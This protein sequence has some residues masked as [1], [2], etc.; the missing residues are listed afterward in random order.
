MRLTDEQLRSEL[1]ELRETPSEEFAAELDAWAAAGFPPPDSER[2]STARRL[3]P[4]FASRVRDLRLRPFLPAMGMATLLI[5]VVIAV[6]TSE[7]VDN[8]DGGDGASID[9]PD[10]IAPES[11]DDSGGAGDAAP[12]AARLDRTTAELAPLTVPPA[13]PQER[14]KPSR[15][16]VQE[17]SASIALSTE[18]DEVD[19]V[20]DG[21]V[22]VTERYEGIVV[23]S[24]V[25]T[26]AERGRAT[27][28]LRIPTASL[29]A[30]LADLSDLASVSARNEG[31]LDI[32]APFVSAEE[33]F[34]DAK[35]E[36]DA[37]LEELA[38][39][40]DASEIAAIRE[41]LRVA[42]GELSRAR[43]ELGA[44]KQRTDFARLAV[45]VSGDGDADGWS[46][47]DAADDA[48]SVLEDLLGAGLVALAVIVPLGGLALLGWIGSERLRRR[49]REA[50]LDE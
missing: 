16:R 30:A 8:D 25:S 3:R 23:R 5:G 19:D 49:R 45:T 14:L 13:P 4:S 40:D 46:L 42:R 37:L 28:D 39:A 21:V 7:I 33:R 32:T 6:G 15:E 17:R 43:S 26:G 36:V 22:E 24:D 11:A 10:M 48:V 50:A 1:T 41:Q 2:G 35:A 27:F 31:T 12:G 29:Q 47:G 38:D 20:A 44:L 34:E 18:A 9:A